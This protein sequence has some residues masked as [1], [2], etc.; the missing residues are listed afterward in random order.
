MALMLNAN[1]PILTFCP[2]SGHQ[3]NSWRLMALEGGCR[4]RQSHCNITIMNYILSFLGSYLYYVNISVTGLLLCCVSNLIVF[5]C[6]IYT[7]KI[8]LYLV[9]IC[10]H[11]LIGLGLYVSSFF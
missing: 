7:V 2:A 3:V 5:K 1:Y 11:D 4:T 9:L 6:N 8:S 10:K